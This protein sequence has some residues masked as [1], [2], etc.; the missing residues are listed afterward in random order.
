MAQDKVQLK[1]EEIVGNDVVLQ[2]IYPKTSTNSITDSTKGIPLDQTLAMIRN[3]INNKLSRVVN[4]VNGR[5]G[6]VILDA[7]DVGLENVDNI[8]FGDIKRW[9]IDY[10]CDIFGTK[11]L[12][13]KEYLSE[14]HTII[15]TNDEA[16]DSTPF[17][18]QKGEAESNDFMGY[19]GYIYWDDEHKT[20]YEEHKSIRVVGYTDRSLIYNVDVGDRKFSHGGLGINIW[21]GDDALKIRNNLVSTDHSPESLADSGLYLDKSKVVPEVYFFDGVYGIISGTG[22]NM[23]NRDALVYW[24]SDPHDTTVGN[25]PMIEIYVNG[26]KTNRYSTSG[27]SPETLHTQ[28]NFKVGDIVLT[29]FSFDQYINPDDDQNRIDV[30]YPGMVD[31]LTCRQPAVGRVTQAADTVTN[32]PCIIQFYTTKPNVSYGLKLINTN[33]SYTTP[34]DTAIGLDLLEAKVS[35]SSKSNISGINALSKHNL[36]YR[37]GKS[38]ETK[39]L[40]TVYPTGKSSNVLDETNGQVEN[41][42]AFILPNFSL[43]VIPGYEMTSISNWNPTSPIGNES[44]TDQSWNM[45]GIN[46]A[47][48]IWSN[49]ENST[50]YENAR[51]ISGLRINTDTDPI[52][53][54]WFGFGIDGDTPIVQK[55]SGGLSVNVGDFLGIG[56]SD[57]LSGKDPIERDVYYDEGKVNV[58]IDRMKG[59]Y[60][61]DGNRLAINIADGGI[62]Q[63]TVP[64]AIKSTWLDGGLKFLPDNERTPGHGPLAINTGMNASGLSIKNDVKSEKQFLNYGYRSKYITEDNVLSIQQ[65]RFSGLN[66]RNDINGSGIELHRVLTH[67]DLARKIYIKNLHTTKIW[68]GTSTL[69]QD[70]ERDESYF[71]TNTV[72]VAGGNYYIY[73][74][75]DGSRKVL[76]YFVY[77]SDENE[78][79]QIRTAMETGTIPPEIDQAYTYSIDIVRRRCHVL[80]T[81]MDPSTDPDKYKVKACVYETGVSDLRFPDFDHDGVVNSSESSTVLNM[82]THN[83][84]SQ[85]IYSDENF[86]NFFTDKDLTKPLQ[87]KVGYRYI[88]ISEYIEDPSDPSHVYYMMYTGKSDSATD[89]VYLERFKVTGERAATLVDIM[90]SDIDRDGMVTS[91]DASLILEYYT[92]CSSGKYPGLSPEESW[93]QFL[94]ERVG[95][96]VVE[97]T[98]SVVDLLDY[99]YE[100]GLRLRYNEMMGLTTMLDCVGGP[101]S[102]NHEIETGTVTENSMKNML[103]IKIADKSAGR[104]AF[105]PTIAGG[106]R[107]GTKGYLG[108][109]VNSRNDNTDYQATLPTH[110]RNVEDMTVGSK[111]L[112]IDNDNVLGIQ[113][114]KD[115]KSDNGDLCFKDGCLYVSPSFRQNA[116]NLTITDGNISI[117]YNGTEDVTITLGPGLCFESYSS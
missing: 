71:N 61:V 53:D 60:G 110:N 16:Y 76:E 62:Y 101:V 51:N 2:D 33:T 93:K 111:G 1:R 88:N 89:E 55:H 92:A 30:L 115:G 96:N 4:S 39:H 13:L 112:C 67:E 85:S 21:S 41:N 84:T 69:F 31:A 26:T 11:R 94:K 50:S 14:I 98:G 99:V 77:Y 6:V 29:N 19:I 65:F 83:Q 80:I 58:R 64:G 103:A 57:E 108:I 49:D 106:L 107:F 23:H 79:N 68:Y 36:E 73:A 72:Y 95:I 27:P 70:I 59:L 34:E 20:L 102:K 66:Y 100:K 40:Y 87:P 109:R 12:I 78:Y 22:E 90:N 46:L 45:L 86:R 42:S 117:P 52:S 5:T 8:S 97:G 25:L 104:Y 9:V 15:G 105:D 81:P 32:K 37:N 75:P 44:F 17:Y 7:G 114:S 43:C 3:M 56:N 63:S 24:S 18:C 38:V 47:K 74:K 113:L 91:I 28:Q 116:N 10:V 82:Y 35:G 54:K 48:H